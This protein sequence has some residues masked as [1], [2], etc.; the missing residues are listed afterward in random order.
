MFL[1]G[2]A[3]GLRTPPR[4]GVFG[5]PLRDSGGAGHSDVAS[6]ICWRI[7]LHDCNNWRWATTLQEAR[8]AVAMACSGMGR[9]AHCVSVKEYVFTYEFP[10]EI[11]D[12][13]W[14]ITERFVNWVAAQL[15]VRVRQE[16]ARRCAQWDSRDADMAATTTAC[17]QYFGDSRI[18]FCVHQCLAST[19][20][21]GR[22][23]CMECTVSLCSPVDT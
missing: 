4:G 6:Q 9:G 19:T 22:G 15:F 7:A 12:S 21:N 10:R 23:V 8:R 3:A 14:S 13:T 16:V 11:G 17:E 20:A 18:V 1:H 5:S 2:G